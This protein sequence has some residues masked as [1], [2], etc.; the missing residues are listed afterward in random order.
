MKYFLVSALALSAIAL[1]TARPSATSG[2][3]YDDYPDNADYP[4]DQDYEATGQGDGAAVEA[5]VVAVVVDGL[6]AVLEQ[7]GNMPTAKRPIEDGAAGTDDQGDNK[8]AE[9]KAKKVSEKKPRKP[10]RINRPKWTSRSLTGG[11]RVPF[12]GGSVR[13]I[14]KK[15]FF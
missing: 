14:G 7:L 1:T 13:K 2:V 9:K 5:Q 10:R 4:Q 6:P 8:T 3:D 11:F 15:R 12:L